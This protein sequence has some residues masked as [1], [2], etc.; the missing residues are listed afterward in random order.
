[1]FSIP[2]TSLLISPSSACKPYPVAYSMAESLKEDIVDIMKMGV[3]RES[4]SP[5][6]SPVVIVK[7][8]D[9][10]NGVCVDYRKLNKLT[11]FDPQPMPAAVNLFQK[12]NG[13]RFFSK[14]NLIKGYWQ[15][16]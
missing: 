8:K 5:Y 14:S 12:S 15:V 11:V 13:D 10:S 2:S 1:M 16:Q 7:K 4:N 6:T 3:I 9:D